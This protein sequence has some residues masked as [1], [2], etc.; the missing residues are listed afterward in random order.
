M[1]RR[2]DIPFPRVLWLFV[3]FIFACGFGHLIE[4]TIFWT[5]VPMTSEAT[6]F[7]PTPLAGTKRLVS[8]RSRGIAAAAESGAFKRPATRARSPRVPRARE[9]RSRGRSP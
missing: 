7:S 9:A 3:A 1:L 6:S 2:K 5:P 8:R 4:A